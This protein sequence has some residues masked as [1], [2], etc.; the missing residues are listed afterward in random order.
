ML[1][2][3]LACVLLGTVSAAGVEALPGERMVPLLPADPHETASALLFRGGDPSLEGVVGDTLGLVRVDAGPIDLQVELGAAIFLGF[4][5][6]GSLT[7]GIS[8]VDGL[9]R[10]PISMSWKRLRM[11]LE[12]AHISAHYADGVRYGDNLPPPS[13]GYSREQLRL[14]S[15]LELPWV[16]PYVALREL[17]HV[18]PEDR[19]FGVQLGL[20][21][22]GQRRFTWYEALDL[23]WHADNDWRTRLSYQGGMLLRASRQRAVRGG[24]TAFWGPALAGKR[25]GEQ[26]AYLG[27]VFGFDWH[28]GWDEWTGSET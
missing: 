18:I 8:P 3:A 28:G 21:A 10:L 13:D 23:A 4:L 27:V 15:S 11:T 9:I 16:R 14:I 5:P 20:K 7:F 1:Q 22:Y 19:R 2:L 24:V 26:D 17:V 6:G 12:W 25:C